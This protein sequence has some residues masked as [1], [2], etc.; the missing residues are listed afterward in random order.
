MGK[1]FGMTLSNGRCPVDVHFD[2]EKWYVDIHGI[3]HHRKTTTIIFVDRDEDF[4]SLSTYTSL[5]GS[6]K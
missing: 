4:W 3:V 5:H 6:T 2:F 1:L